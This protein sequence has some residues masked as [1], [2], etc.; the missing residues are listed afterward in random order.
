M[1]RELGIFAIC[2]LTAN[3]AFANYLCVADA[4]TGFLYNE[5]TK[6]W[7]SAD[8]TVE[9]KRYILSSKDGQW[10]WGTFGEKSTDRCGTFDVHDQIGC[11]DMIKV[12]F[13]KATMRYQRSYT[14]VSTIRPRGEAFSNDTPFIEIGTCSPI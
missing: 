6:R 1:V 7:V 14:A 12:T 5:K 13:N 4:R 3:A 11:G 10:R 9:G 2:F 8:F